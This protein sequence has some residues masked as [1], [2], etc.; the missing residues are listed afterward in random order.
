MLNI[1]IFIE[2]NQKSISNKNKILYQ[3][4]FIKQ[5]DNKKDNNINIKRERKKP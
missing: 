4:V 1:I 3:K 2:Y 5:K